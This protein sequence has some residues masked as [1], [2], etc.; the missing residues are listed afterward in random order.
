M[1]LSW[2][3]ELLYPYFCWHR[4]W[5]KNQSWWADVLHR[6]SVDGKFQLFPLSALVMSKYLRVWWFQHQ[7]IRAQ[8]PSCMNITVGWDYTRSVT[9]AVCHRERDQS[10]K[11]QLTLLRWLELTNF[12]TK[13]SSRCI[14]GTACLFFAAAAWLKMPPLLPATA[15]LHGN[16]WLAWWL[17]SVWMCVCVCVLIE[18]YF[19]RPHETH[20]SLTES[21]TSS[22]RGKLKTNKH[23]KATDERVGLIMFCL[24]FF[25]AV[26]NDFDLKFSLIFLH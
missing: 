4:N 7:P 3:A 17:K 25:F 13:V 10:R 21:D 18:V 24:V 22:S 14:M 1:K 15:R 19:C 23:V 16:V 2:A 20:D 8:N 26:L 6:S 5:C 9:S 11:D 12:A